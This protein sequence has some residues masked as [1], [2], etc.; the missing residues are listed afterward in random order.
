MKRNKALYDAERLK[1]WKER[2]LMNDEDVRL[3]ILYT[4]MQSKKQTVVMEEEA[5]DLREQELEEQ[6]RKY[7]LDSEIEKHQLI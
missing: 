2:K 1:E 4:E 5:K 6:W 7:L 3:K